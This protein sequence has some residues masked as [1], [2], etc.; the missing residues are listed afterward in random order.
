MLLFISRKICGTAD[1]LMYLFEKR[2]IDAFRLNLD[3]F[4]FYKFK[5]CNDEFEI[6]DPIGRKFHSQNLDSAIFYKGIFTIDEPLDFDHTHVEPKWLKSYLNNIY[7]CIASYAINKNK[8][9]LW[10]PQ[11]V[12]YP[13][14]LQ[15]QMAKEF[16]DVPSFQIH[17]G[18]KSESKEVI[19]KPLTQRYFENGTAMFATKVNRADLSE[20]YPWFTQNIA[21]GDRDATVVYINGNVHCYEFASKRNDLTDWRVV[22]GTKRNKWRKW[23]AGKD[24]ERRIDLYMKKMNLK[25]GRLDF[26]IGGKEPQFLEVNPTGQFGWLDDRKFTLHNEVIDAI[27]DES[28]RITI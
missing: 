14:T 28:S 9:K 7:F 13:K 3:L 26:I 4:N 20:D 1:A 12:Y 17:W 19:A 11:E 22:Q 6:E 15:M 5:W 2:K 8:V 24:F 25:F 18:F 23:N 16:F 10:L 27:L 21:Q